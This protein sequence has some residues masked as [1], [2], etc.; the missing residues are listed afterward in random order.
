MNEFE[1]KQQNRELPGFPGR[2]TEICWECN[3]RPAVR[4]EQDSNGIKGWVCRDCGRYGPWARSF[5]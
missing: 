2:Q 1:K 3:D 5:A 4:I